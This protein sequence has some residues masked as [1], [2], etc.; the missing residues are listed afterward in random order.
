MSMN[1]EYMK[2]QSFID[3]NTSVGGSLMLGVPLFA[4]AMLED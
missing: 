2:G 4:F 1:N 3:V